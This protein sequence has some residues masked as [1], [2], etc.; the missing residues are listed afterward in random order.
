MLSLD[1]VVLE[2]FYPVR[3]RYKDHFLPDELSLL[4][5]FGNKTWKYILHVIS[6]L[7]EVDYS[8][9][10]ELSDGLGHAVDT[11]EMPFLGTFRYVEKGSRFMLD[12][13]GVLIYVCTPVVK[14]S[15]VTLARSPDC[16]YRDIAPSGTAES[17]RSASCHATRSRSDHQVGRCFHARSRIDHRGKHLFSELLLVRDGESFL[18]ALYGPNNAR[19]RIFSRRVAQT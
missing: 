19:L 18:G 12:F 11:S 8:H 7:V 2:V 17:I 6:L 5:S 10:G 14:V 9:P 1:G 4:L 15:N 16:S 3:P 13:A